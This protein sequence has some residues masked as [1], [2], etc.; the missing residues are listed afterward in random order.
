LLRQL[1]ASLLC[2]HEKAEKLMLIVL[3]K[4]EGNMKEL[5]LEG[6]NI[7]EMIMKLYEIS[8]ALANSLVA[9]WHNYIAVIK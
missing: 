5:V 6:W 2:L 7:T 4:F 8:P 9:K 1:G 3:K